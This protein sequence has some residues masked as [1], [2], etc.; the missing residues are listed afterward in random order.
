MTDLWLTGRLT[1]SR[2]AIRTMAPSPNPSRSRATQLLGA[3]ILAAVLAAVGGCKTTESAGATQ[4]PQAAT[5][6]RPAASGPILGTG[7]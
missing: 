4:R 1:S 6:A 7:Y 3:L 2:K 5:P